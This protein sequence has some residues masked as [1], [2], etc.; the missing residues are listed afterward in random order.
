M[1]AH[2]RSLS[3]LFAQ[4]I[5]YVVPLFQRP[6]VWK[7]DTQ[8]EPLWQDIQR[9]A[10][11][12][13]EGANGEGLAHFLGSVVLSQLQT[14]TGE[15]IARQVID[16]QQRLTTL[17]ILFTAIRDFAQASGSENTVHVFRGLTTNQTNPGAP[18]DHLQKV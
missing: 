15:V 8:W 2:D 3:A 12:R 9:L 5:R 13:L 10:E 4:P 14:S 1:Q 16:G 17:Q 11:K 18:A 7:R 6:Y